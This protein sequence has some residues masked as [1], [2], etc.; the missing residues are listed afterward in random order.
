MVRKIVL[1]LCSQKV[2]I[3]LDYHSVCLLV[4]IGTPPPHPLF[5]EPKGG[6]HS[7]AGEGVGGSQLGRLE[8]NPSTL[9]TQCL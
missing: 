3:Y 4:R 7:P 8:K 1:D 5:P 9:S 2:Y 6:T